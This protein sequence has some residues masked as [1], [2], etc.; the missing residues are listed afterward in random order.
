MNKMLTYIVGALIIYAIVDSK[1]T[2]KQQNNV[3]KKHDANEQTSKEDTELDISPS[4]N[5][6]EKSLSNLLV[7]VLKTPEGRTFFENMIQPKN[8]STLGDDLGFKLNG[9]QIIEGLFKIQTNGEGTVGPASCGHV[10]HANYQIL[11][12]DNII[13]EESKK[14]FRLGSNEIMPGLENVIIG[15][16]IGQ[17]RSAIIP[18]SFAYN[19]QLSEDKKPGLNY[20]VKVTLI[21]IIPKTFITKDVKIF[22]DAIAY[23]TPCICGS[24]VS[25]DMLVTKINGE[26]VYNSKTTGQK[27]QMILGDMSYPMIIS[28]GLTGKIPVG[29]RTIIAQGKYFRSLG[30]AKI[31]NIFKN[32]Q[33]PMDEYFLIEFSDLTDNGR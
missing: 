25:F 29:N 15:M 32:Q 19:K 8:K 12:M 18:A 33:L 2:E 9:T 11:T 14:T 6:F 1:M 22:D 4:G 10:V 3:I 26:V 7:N 21:D 31:N 5:M 23:K 20:Q 24:R 27:I 17:T 16:Y 28:H 13:V 30:D